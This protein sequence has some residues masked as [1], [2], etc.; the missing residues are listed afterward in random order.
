ML[1]EAQIKILHTL[2]RRNED[3][4]I[5]IQ[6]DW[7][8]RTLAALLRRGFCKIN[9][10]GHVTATVRGIQTL[11]WINTRIWHHY[12]DAVTIASQAKHRALGR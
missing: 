7:N 9:S 4:A 2:A 6:R 1:T 8:I 12:P 10:K 5:L 3:E 11:H